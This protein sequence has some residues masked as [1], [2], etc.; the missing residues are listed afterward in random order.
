MMGQHGMDGIADQDDPTAM[1][2]AKR[3]GDEQAPAPFDIARRD[4]LAH[5]RMPVG[6]GHHRVTGLDRRRTATIG[7]SGGALHR[8]EVDM[9]AG[10]AE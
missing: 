5:G 4:H 8:E 9:P 1:P 2:M 6:K 10:A 7:P 3:R